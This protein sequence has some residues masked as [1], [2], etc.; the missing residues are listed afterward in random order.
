MIIAKTKL[1][2]V[3]VFS[4]FAVLH[5]KEFFVKITNYDIPNFS[6]VIL[7]L[8]LFTT[9]MSKR[10]RIWSMLAFLT[11][12]IFLVSYVNYLLY[13]LDLKRF[14]YGFYYT[15]SFLILFY[16]FY[17]LK[18]DSSRIPFYLKVLNVIIICIL[19]IGYLDIL[20][21]RELSSGFLRNTSFNL[22]QQCP[23]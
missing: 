10:T 14:L 23:F 6:F 2:I 8:L 19:I 4:C 16:L 21:F 20:I 15:F 7:N 18:I 9:L 12:V 1:Q 5:L 13:G 17:N 3:L 22:H 11:F